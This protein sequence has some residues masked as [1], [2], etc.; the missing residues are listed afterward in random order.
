MLLNFRLL[1][2]EQRF[3][4]ADDFFYCQKEE[5]LNISGAYNLKISY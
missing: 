1:E 3:L 5:I 2:T 4:F